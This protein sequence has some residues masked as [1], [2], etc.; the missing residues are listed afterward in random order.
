MNL[1]T[2][3]LDHDFGLA[4]IRKQQSLLKSVGKALLSFAVGLENARE[5]QIKV[6][7]GIPVEKAFK[8]VYGISISRK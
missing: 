6:E 7:K 3:T 5:M 2:N 4:P 1:N 8:S